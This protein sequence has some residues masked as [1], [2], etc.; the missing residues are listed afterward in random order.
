MTYATPLNLID[1]FGA[2]E[3]AQRADLG[4][5]RLVASTML[6]AAAAGG[7]LAGYTE[8]ERAAT[9]A[10]LSRIEARL[11]DASSVINGYLSARYQVP[12]LSVPRLVVMIACDLARYALYDDMAPEMVE[13]RY[14]LAIKQLEAISAGKISL[15]IDL[16]GNRP[17]VAGG[18]QVVSSTPV[19]RRGRSEGFI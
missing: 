8:D 12:L 15:G 17:G 13:S 11:V 10:A 6:T 16:A 2:E 1:Q 4:E 14:K 3:L 9:A 7:S 19:F 18:A 5:P